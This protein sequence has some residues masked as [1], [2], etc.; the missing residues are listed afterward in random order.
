MKM[1]EGNKYDDGENI[2]M[3]F[4]QVSPVISAKDD[5]LLCLWMALSRAMWM[6]F[7]RYDEAMLNTLFWVTGFAVLVEL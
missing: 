7:A 6:V 4:L 2:C 1:A 5:T 3:H